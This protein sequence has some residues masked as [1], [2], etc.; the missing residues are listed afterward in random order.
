M[1]LDIIFR[2]KGFSGLKALE[3]GT[4]QG[5]SFPSKVQFSSQAFKLDENGNEIVQD[6]IFVVPLEKYSN[7]LILRDKLDEIRKK[8]VILEFK[9][10]I[11]M[12]TGGKSQFQVKVSDS[13]EF[14]KYID[15]LL[16]K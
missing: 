4:F 11:P 14:V 9:T 10:Q 16:K 8:N 5:I 1:S 6:I 2:V 7:A 3:S 13:N 12:P 15:S